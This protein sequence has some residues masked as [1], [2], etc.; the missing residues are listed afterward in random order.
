MKSLAELMQNRA[1]VTDAAAAF[2]KDA[3]D[4]GRALKPDEQRRLSLLLIEAESISKEIERA[5]EHQVRMCAQAAAD[6]Q[7]LR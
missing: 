5:R 1:K 4:Q 6:A 7:I 3:T 2:L